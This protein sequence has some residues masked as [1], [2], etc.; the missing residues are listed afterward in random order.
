MSQTLPPAGNLDFDL[1]TLLPPGTRDADRTG[2]ARVTYSYPIPVVQAEIS[3]L[4]EQRRHAYTIVGQSVSS[5]VW[6]SAYLAFRAPTPNTYLETA[7]FNPQEKDVQV[8]LGILAGQGWQPIESFTL[9]PREM[10]K[11]RIPATRLATA[12]SSAD[13]TALFR[14]TYSVSATELV[15]NA[16]LEDET[17]GFS[18]TVLFHDV[19][20]TSNRLYGA[21]MVAY[22]YPRDLLPDGP[23]FD[24]HLVL[25]N[26][27]QEAQ[28]VTPTLHC[29][30][31]GKPSTQTLPAFALEPETVRSLPLNQ[32]LADQF[33]HAAEAICS[34]EIDFT[35]APG[36]LLGRYFG[37]SSSLTYGLYSKLEAGLGH[38][39]NELYWN[40][41]GDRTPLLTVTNFSDTTERIDI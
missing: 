22:G 36:T 3:I 5:S 29:D 15:A 16:W 2:G 18:N 24:G 33:G 37:E 40:V 41:E 28:T 25:A 11:L 12:R 9:A 30:L 20:P 13:R 31:G 6:H 14:A 39:Y 35:G 1:A 17:T 21:Q 27:G 19:R 7:F 26:I 34:A 32:I 8:G 23:T 38:A 10:R 4:D